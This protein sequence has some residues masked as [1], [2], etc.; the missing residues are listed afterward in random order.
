MRVWIA[1]WTGS[2]VICGRI[3]AWIA[4]G[5]VPRLILLVFVAG[6]AKGLHRTTELAY[7][8][9]G[10]WIVT[11]ITLGLRPPAAAAAPAA[12]EKPALT[13]E[14]VTAAMHQLAAPHVQL[15]PLAEHLSTT[16]A[17]LRTV[18]GE[19]GVPIAGGVR[20]KGHGVS[21]GVKAEDL[22][23]RSPTA[24]PGTEGALT[25]DNNSN[26]AL[27]VERQA[28]MSIIRDPADRKRRR[29]LLR[30]S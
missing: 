18:L 11:A 24:A 3:G 22:P 23:P 25:S 26:N 7:T 1:I 13:P 9:A 28:G 10:A 16:T 30:R 27:I 20:M 6:F 19:M 12:P 4:G 21:T 17:A 2:T 29:T 8:A 14:A 15:A 5:P